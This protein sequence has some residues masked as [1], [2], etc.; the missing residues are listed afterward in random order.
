MCS[1]S[2]STLYSALFPGCLFATRLSPLQHA[3]TLHFTSGSRRYNLES[4]LFLLLSAFPETLSP[5]VHSLTL[6]FSFSL[7]SPSV[8]Y[9]KPTSHCVHTS[10]I[11]RSGSL[12][13]TSSSPSPAFPI[14]PLATHRHLRQILA[15]S[16]SPQPEASLRISS[17]TSTTPTTLSPST[18]IPLVRS[19]ARCLKFLFFRYICACNLSLAR[20]LPLI[21]LT[22]YPSITHVV[23][24]CPD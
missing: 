14:W 22:G 15:Y 12:E 6:R 7:F 18:T 4:R 5:R 17:L 19:G 8:L 24:A 11:L 2:F 21:S 20:S 23:D 3:H 1:G 16:P 10:T 13:P 9:F